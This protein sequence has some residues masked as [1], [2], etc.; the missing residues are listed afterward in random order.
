MAKSIKKDRKDR[1]RAWVLK[2]VLLIT[3]GALFSVFQNIACTTKDA[4]LAQTTAVQ[5]EDSNA[6][7]AY[8]TLN[9]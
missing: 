2:A 4:V 1:Q 6:G 7:Y 9:R 5:L 8:Q 3:C